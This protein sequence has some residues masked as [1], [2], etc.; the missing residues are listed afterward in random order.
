MRGDEADPFV[1]RRLG[2]RTDGVYGRHA[3]D[4][5]DGVAFAGSRLVVAGGASGE[6][7][8]LDVGDGSAPRQTARLGG[9]SNV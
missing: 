2:T 4:G 8:I 6:V 5:G 1:P 7:V 3:D 9:M